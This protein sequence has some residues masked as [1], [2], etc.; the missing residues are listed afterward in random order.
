MK[1][2]LITGVARGIGRALAE[3]FMAADYQVIGTVEH[4]TEIAPLQNTTTLTLD[5]ASEESIED[6][7]QTIQA[8]DIKISILVNNAGTLVDENETAV[9][10]E[11]LTQ[12]LAVNLIGTIDFTERIIPLLEESAHI[13]NVSSSAGSLSLVG[14]ESHHEGHY[15]SYK[16]SKAAL[17][18]YTRTLALR[19]E[20]HAIVSSVHPGWTK[21]TIGG[22]N[23]D[24]TPKQAA[25]QIYTLATSSPATGRFW[26]EGKEYPW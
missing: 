25:E 17:N 10:R 22:T 2:V 5:L 21:T 19:L 7:V 1:T 8:Q 4:E 6:C 24:H 3:R 16:I 11:T 9:V 26:Y 12:T 20:R 13:V 15:P 23:A 14:H 18:M